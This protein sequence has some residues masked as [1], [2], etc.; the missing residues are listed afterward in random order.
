MGILMHIP[1]MFV[2]VPVLPDQLVVVRGEWRDRYY[3]RTVYA[4][5]NDGNDRDHHNYVARIDGDLVELTCEGDFW[6]E[7]GWYICPV[8]K[9]VRDYKED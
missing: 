4:W 5:V 6:Y 8:I 7:D 3:T 1:N 2:L 9:V